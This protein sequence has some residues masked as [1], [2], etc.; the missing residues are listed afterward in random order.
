MIRISLV[1]L[2]ALAAACTTPADRPPEPLFVIGGEGTELV[3][4]PDWSRDGSRLAY[5]EVVEGRSAIF[6]AGADGQD[7][8]RL[9]HGV[10]DAE[11]AWSPDGQWIA[12]YSDEDADIYVVPA[13]GGE[14]RQVTSGPGQDGVGGWMPDGSALIVER[15][16]EGSVQTL[17]VPLDGGAPRPVGVVP[18]AVTR[19]F[20]SPDGSQLVMQVEQAGSMTIWIQPLPDG[21]PRQLT[22]EGFED[23]TT[24]TAWS[25]DGR[26][27]LY[28]SRRT[29]TADLW[30]VEAAT[31]AT[32]Q[33][34]ND[35]R[36][37][38]AGRWSPD[39][40]WVAF[41]STRG[42]QHDVWLV[43]AAGG[44]ATR[45]TNN[46]DI[47]Q[48]LNWSPD[49][50]A[51][52]FTTADS[53]PTVGQVAL[54]GGSLGTLA[55][56]DGPFLVQALPSPD[57][58]QI[59]MG[60]SRSGNDDLLVVPVAGGDPRLLAGGPTAE[61]GGAWS[62]DGSQVVFA[63]NRGGTMDLWIVADTGGEARQLTDWSPSRENTPRWSP[64]GATIAF[65]SNREAGVAELWTVPS[66]GGAGRRLAPGLQVQDFSWS[67]DGQT[68]FADAVA[69]GG[70]QGLYA[71]PASG[72]PAQALLEGDVDV[73][74]PMVS[75]D[76]TMLAYTRF[77]GG[78]G[79]LEVVAV[80]G[81]TPRRLTTRTDAVYHTG[82]RWSPDGSLIVVEDFVLST[83]GQE[84]E[85]VSWPGGE[86]R[87]LAAV[88]NRSMLGPEW[89][90]D[91]RS[92]VFAESDFSSRIV[93][94]PVPR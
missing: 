13:A 67:P 39:G 65:L 34:T 7:P 45:L 14:R 66:A 46:R 60:G 63:S 75:P 83:S 64:D 84:L 11:P 32:R 43:P 2:L 88:P 29:G 81:G 94:L 79:W 30:V 16:S 37:D 89:L 59:L 20:P 44:D 87:R 48:D 27:I 85:V 77:G 82:P 23:P 22:T 51:V 5:A 17:V 76:G 6:V 54:E 33:L 61:S 78:W 57:G 49:G 74:R 41:L 90:P 68:L 8:V 28:E 40:Q 52:A 25:P 12:Y 69:A 92:V 72:G 86:W 62:P 55:G 58:S 9:T 10:W 38:F 71:I 35:V 36:D 50:R 21:E 91:G 80:T 1:C 56:W 18:G 15:T 19:G 53:R 26:F 4:A 42:G 31:G 70:T 93:A 47:E 3:S 73:G 24:P